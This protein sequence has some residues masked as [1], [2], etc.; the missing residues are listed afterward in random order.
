MSE[1]YVS[2]STLW[3]MGDEAR[4]S[5]ANALYC[6]F[7]KQMLIEAAKGNIF[8]RYEIEGSDWSIVD[9]LVQ[10]IFKEHPGVGG[11]IRRNPNHGEL[12]Y[13]IISW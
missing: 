6:L 2:A 11:V 12:S 10:K 1:P 13:I 5:R 4:D 8:V 7:Y 9:R 3:E